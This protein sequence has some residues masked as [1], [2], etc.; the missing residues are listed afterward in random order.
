MDDVTKPDR[1]RY[2]TPAAVAVWIVLMVRLMIADVWDETNGMLYFS[3][4]ANSLGEIVRFVLTQ[5]LG[6]W[7]PLPTLLAGA[8]MHFLPDFAVSWRVLRAINMALLVGAIAIL[9]AFLLVLYQIMRIAMTSDNNFSKLICL[10]TSIMFLLHFIV[11]TGS[12]LGLMPVIGVPFPFL[13][14]GGS[15]LLVSALLIG[16]IQ[17]GVQYKRF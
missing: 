17:S 16:M 2:A 8:V 6:F 1:W 7:R 4:P 5:S 10:G 11:N 12:N 13:S 14:Y 9:A 3:D 15:N